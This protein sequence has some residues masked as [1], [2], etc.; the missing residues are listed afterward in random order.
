MCSDL[1]THIILGHQELILLL[2]DLSGVLLAQLNVFTPSNASIYWHEYVQ[3]NIK[4]VAF[5]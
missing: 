5:G 1:T 3:Q 2:T 4:T